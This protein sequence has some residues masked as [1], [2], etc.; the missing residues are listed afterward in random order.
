MRSC[1][2]PLNLRARVFWGGRGGLVVAPS[3][4][5]KWPNENSS[6]TVTT[7]AIVPPFSWSTCNVL[8]KNPK[9][10]LPDL[11]STKEASASAL[12]RMRFGSA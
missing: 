5:E 3:Q 4:E 10:S 7:A 9:R 8:R 2:A 12:K 1:L 6:W 11:T